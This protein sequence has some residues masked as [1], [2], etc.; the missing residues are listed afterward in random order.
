LFPPKGLLFIYPPIPCSYYIREV[1]E[2]RIDKF[3]LSLQG[4]DNNAVSWPTIA[5]DN[6]LFLFDTV[7]R[8][9]F[10]TTGVAAHGQGTAERS[11]GS[12]QK[13]GVCR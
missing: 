3:A 13:K 10:L 9:Y 4:G 2:S 11:C 7:R 8:K 1:P 5:T 6:I 12:F